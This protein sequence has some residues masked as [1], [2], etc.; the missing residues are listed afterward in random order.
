MRSGCQGLETVSNYNL[1]VVNFTSSHGNSR[2]EAKL[3]KVLDESL[4]FGVLGD[5]GLGLCEMA[6]V[7]PTKVARGDWKG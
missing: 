1:T 7:A 3:L 5:K 6:G 4:S 2:L